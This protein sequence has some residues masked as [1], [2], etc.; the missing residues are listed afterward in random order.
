MFSGIVEIISKATK[1]K[2]EKGGLRLYFN[3]SS[4]FNVKE[5]ES[6]SVDGI[7]STVEK[8]AKDSFGFYYMPETLRKTT[9]SQVSNSHMFNLERPLTLGSL[10]SGH[11][12][13][14]HIDTTA[15]VSSIKKEQDAKL[16]KFKIDKKFT[17]HIIYKGS[18]AVNGVSLT[19]VDVGDNIFSVS[20][21]PYT[22]SNTNLGD[23]KV[24][25][26]VNIEVDMIAKYV[27]KLYKQ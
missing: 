7:C 17:R 23:L 21:I 14:G 20:L 26:S 3:H 11:L 19:V 9:L 13:S 8:I 6:I 16:I 2:K 12:V 5:G 25:D 10:V 27:E 22:L 1:I 4:D 18:I 24:G 15:K